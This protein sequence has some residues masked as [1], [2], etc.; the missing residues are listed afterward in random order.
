MKISLEDEIKIG[1]RGDE[2][3]QYEAICSAYERYAA[4]LAAFLRERWGATFDEHELKTAVN[5]VFV[6]LANKV[7]T[8]NFGANGSLATLLFEMAKC[9]AID[10]WKKKVRYQKRHVLVGYV[11]EDQQV[12]EVLTADEIAAVVAKRL[13]E[14]PEIGA[15]WKSLTQQRTAADEAAT[16]EVVRLFKIWLGTLPRLQRK[17][18][19]LIAICFGEISDE[20]I[21]ETLNVPL[22]SVKSA[23]REIREKFTAL[24]QRQ[25]RVNTP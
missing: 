1:L 4:P 23:R 13:V 11:A 25:E 14:A 9:N 22:G 5:D 12:P 7:K 16:E 15:A 21:S 6:E 19:E 2:Q 17:V 10:L 20:E 3:T 8:G 24:I 18:A